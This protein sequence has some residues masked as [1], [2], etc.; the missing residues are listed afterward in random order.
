MVAAS[1]IPEA[2]TKATAII[3]SSSIALFIPL[4]LP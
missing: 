1:A 3:A 2:D 4:L